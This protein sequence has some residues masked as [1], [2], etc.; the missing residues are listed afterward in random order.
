V[1]TS[2]KIFHADSCVS[3]P[4]CSCEIPV[5]GAIRLP[6]EFSVLCPNCGLR[7]VY[8]ATELHDAK[9]DTEE[10]HKSRRIQFGKKKD[11]TSGGPKSWLSESM[12][13][14]QHCRHPE[15][16]SALLSPQASPSSTIVR[17]IAPQ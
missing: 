15:L 3:C 9:Q 10:T 2:R 1:A 5:L 17:W 13:W 11:K 4:T 12:S 16:P 14:L 7:R 8:Q 6:R